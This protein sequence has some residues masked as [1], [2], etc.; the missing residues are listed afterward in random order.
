MAKSKRKTNKAGWSAI[1]GEKL[2]VDID[3]KKAQHPDDDTNDI[4]KWTSPHYNL[5]DDDNNSA[6]SKDL[7]DPDPKA[8]GNRFNVEDGAVDF[9][10]FYSLEVISGAWDMIMFTIGFDVLMSADLCMMLC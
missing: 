3:P 6:A 2:T 4:S 1:P 9:G 8:D 7:Y 10:M 5:E